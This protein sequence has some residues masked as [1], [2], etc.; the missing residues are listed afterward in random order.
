MT[1]RG[2]GRRLVALFCV[3]LSFAASAAAQSSAT[4]T[5]KGTVTDSSG[6]VLPGASVVVTNRETNVARSSVSSGAGEW[7][8]PTLP[9]GRYDVAVELDGFKKS[10]QSDVQVEAGVARQLN[11]TLQVG[12]LTENVTVQ[13]D[14]P[15]VVTTT[16][17]TF[18][19]IAAEE[20][21]EVPTSTRSFA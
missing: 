10:T 18:R 3:V 7:T 2:S 21:T 14:V 12:A 1:I 17:A 13:A 9:V 16:A 4:G 15:L 20:L 6:G 8:I 11:V 5:I 19:R